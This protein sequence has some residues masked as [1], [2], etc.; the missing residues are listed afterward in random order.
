MDM[1]KSLAEAERELIKL[2]AERDALDRRINGLVQVIDGLRLISSDVDSTT[3][4]PLPPPN[5]EEVGITD[6]VRNYF[7]GYAAGPVFPVEIRDAV[8][9]AGY[10]GNGPQSVLLAVHSVLSRMERSGEV[11]QVERDGKNAYRWISKLTRAV[12]EMEKNKAAAIGR[13]L[14]TLQHTFG[15]VNSRT[16]KE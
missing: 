12:R 8:M 5:M 6:A 11:E 7:I 2:A 3:K 9:A 1:K 15:N 16:K 10:S 4:L 14:K 13:N